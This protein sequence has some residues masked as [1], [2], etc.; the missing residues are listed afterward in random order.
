MGKH[1]DIAE[2]LAFAPGRA[3]NVILGRL[4]QAI[5]TGITPMAINCPRNGNWPSPSG[6]RDPPSARCSINSNK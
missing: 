4:K 5:E 1:E 2:V 6:Q 3:N